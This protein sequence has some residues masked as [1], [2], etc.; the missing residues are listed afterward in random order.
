[1]AG[2]LLKEASQRQLAIGGERELVPEQV[3]VA[4][5][6]LRGSLH[7]CF[8]AL[9]IAAKS[10]PIVASVSSPMFEMRKVVPLILP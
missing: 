1:M 5:K 2:K 7:N 3:E 8:I 9:S 6:V 4:R 10:W